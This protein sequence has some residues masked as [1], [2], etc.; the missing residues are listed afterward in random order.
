M[1]EIAAGWAFA[2]AFVPEDEAIEAARDAAHQFGIEPVSPAVGAALAL[3]ATASPTGA[4]IE[5]GTG[6]GVSGLWLLKGAPEAQLTTIDRDL[7]HH[8]VARPLFQAAGH[9][10]RR[11]RLIT[12]SAEDV[13]PRMNEQAYDLVFVDADWQG[14][15]EHVETALRLVRPGGSVLVAH[16]LQQGRVANP[17]KRDVRTVAYREL[18]RSVRE[19]PSVLSGLSIVGDGLLHIVRRA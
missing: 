5:I 8:Q 12:G 9:L 6:T 3:A 19:R 17:A 13:L 4:F 10:P 7:D 14:V 2:D 1:A 11:T 15:Q 18:L 16:V